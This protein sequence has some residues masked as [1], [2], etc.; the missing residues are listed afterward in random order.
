MKDKINRAISF[1][2][3]HKGSFFWTPPALASKRRKMEGSERGSV[4]VNGKLIEWEMT[5]RVSAKHVYYSSEICVDGVKK[6]IRA[7]KKLKTK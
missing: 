5:V 3:K 4:T 1:H 6:D 2:E 7:L